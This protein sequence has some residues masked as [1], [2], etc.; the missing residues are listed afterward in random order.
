[1][2]R[3]LLLPALALY[4]LSIPLLSY[5]QDSLSL[6]NQLLLE[7]AQLQWAPPTTSYKLSKKPPQVFQA[8]HFA[9][10]IRKQPALEVRYWLQP[11]DSMQS[12]NFLPNIKA[13]MLAV[14]LAANEE[15]SVISSHR[16]DEDTVRDTLQAD[17]AQLYTLTPKDIYSDKQHCQLLALYRDEIALAYVFLLFDDPPVNLPQWMYS[18]RFNPLQPSLMTSD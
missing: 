5:C 9:A 14:H 10:T 13:G 15:D 16:L 3:L 18:L 4:L 2:Y 12:E 7:T 8:C 11:V 1:M 17:W 6:S